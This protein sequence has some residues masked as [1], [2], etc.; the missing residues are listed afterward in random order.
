MAKMLEFEDLKTKEE[1]KEINTELEG[2]Y[3]LVIPPGTPSAIIYDLVEEFDLEPLD[4]KMNVDIVECDVR[5]VL[6]LRGKLEPIQAAEQFLYD[7]LNA[8]VNEDD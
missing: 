6:C 1:W 4:R 2:M 5:E 3:D 7:E 8:W